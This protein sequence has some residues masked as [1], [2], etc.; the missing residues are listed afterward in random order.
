MKECYNSGVEK[1]FHVCF[2]RIYTIQI[3]AAKLY[4][5]E[6]RENTISDFYCSRELIREVNNHFIF[7]A[8]LNTLVF[9]TA[10]LGNTL[11]II[12]LYKESSL[13]PASKIQD[14]VLCVVLC[15]LVLSFSL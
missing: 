1:V 2:F 14:P 5:I 9:A 7:L 13:N 15:V 6:L 4:W 8:V 3:A 12:A 10:F 11:A